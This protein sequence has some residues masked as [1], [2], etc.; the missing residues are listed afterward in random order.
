M[1]GVSE[2]GEEGEAV[3]NTKAARAL[4]KAAAALTEAAQAMETEGAPAPKTERQR[5]RRSPRRLTSAS[6]KD[7]VYFIGGDEGP[8]KIGY[9]TWVARRLE[10]FQAV[11]PVPMRVLARMP[12]KRAAEAEFHRRFDAGRLHGEWFERTPE[13]LALIDQIAHGGRP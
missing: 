3:T 11:S 13:L 10:E 5:K 8:I 2:G 1:S 12:G 9:S 7:E 6:R 4:R